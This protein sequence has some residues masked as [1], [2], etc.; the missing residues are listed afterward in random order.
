MKALHFALAPCFLLLL[1]CGEEE[2][3]KEPAQP[4]P[5]GLSLEFHQSFDGQSFAMNEWYVTPAGDSVKLSRLDYLMSNI[6]LIKQNGDTIYAEDKNNYALVKAANGMGSWEFGE[7][8]SGTYQGLG[9]D[10]GLEDFIN[11][12]NPNQWSAN[13]PLNPIHNGLHWGWADGYVFTALEGRYMSTAGT[14][15]LLLLHIAFQKNRRAV[16]FNQSIEVTNNTV[17]EIDYAVDQLFSA[18][19]EYRP[20]RDGS[21]THSSNTDGG[22]STMVSANIPAS[23]SI[24]NIR[25]E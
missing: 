16:Y 24:Q 12:S 14:E 20:E 2:P 23:M 25:Q 9:F 18:V 7:V 15:E 4:E 6:F 22:L 5:T 17:I 19:N 8:L 10:I 3:P 11:T 13:H 21:F 1:N